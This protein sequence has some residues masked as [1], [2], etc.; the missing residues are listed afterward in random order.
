MKK[1]SIRTVLSLPETYSYLSYVEYQ[2][3]TEMKSEY[4]SNYPTYLGEKRHIFKLVDLLS[5]NKPRSLVILQSQ[6]LK[7]IKQG[8][9]KGSRKIP[10]Y[11]LPVQETDEEEIVLGSDDV[12]SEIEVEEPESDSNASLNLKV[13]NVQ[14]YV[15]H[16]AHQSLRYLGPN[17]NGQFISN[18]VLTYIQESIFI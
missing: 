1:K 4:L 2:P 18:K 14:L 8:C 15:Y 9:V 10:K 16:K 6:Q 13:D 17:S 11:F 5:K 12:D 3:K 7:N